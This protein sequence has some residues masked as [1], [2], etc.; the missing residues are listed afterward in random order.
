TRRL[1]GRVARASRPRNSQHWRDASATPASPTPRA[2][3][4][5]EL[6]VVITI[7][8]ILIALLLPAVQAAREAARRLQCQNNIKQLSLACIGHEETHGHYPTGGWGYRWLGDPDRGFDWH[9]P[10]GWIFNVLPWLEQQALRDIG[11]GETDEQKKSSR[12]RLATQPLFMCSCPTRRAPLLYP[13][14]AGP[15]GAPNFYNANYSEIT[16]VPRPDYAMNAGSQEYNYIYDGPGSYIQG[17]DSLR[18][19]LTPTWEA[20][21]DTHNGVSYMM[22]MIT[23]G[24]VSDGLS[25]TYLIGE[26]YLNPDHYTTGLDGADNECLMQGYDND[27][28]RCTYSSPM[29]DTPGMPD[30]FSFGSAHAGGLHMS[31]CDGSV[32]WISYT[33][34]EPIHRLLG[35]RADGAP[36]DAKEY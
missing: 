31:F 27:H 11:A 9:Q 23:V 12:L 22:S 8:G 7:I 30:G 6:L 13:F 20:V 35:S 14:G 5:V 19:W 15:S 3:T 24:Q 34:A 28:Y 18:P 26:K 2:F 25:N 17:D 33:I 29:Q 32:Q 4:L 16:L 10:G 1:N 36:I 21:L